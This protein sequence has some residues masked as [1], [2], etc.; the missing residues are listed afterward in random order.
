MMRKKRWKN[1]KRRSGARP[2][3]LNY[4]CFKPASDLARFPSASSHSPRSQ[5]SHPHTAS[6][7]GRGTSVGHPDNVTT[8]GRTKTILLV[9]DEKGVRGFVRA[10][11]QAKG[12]RVFEASDGEEAIH[13]AELFADKIE[14]LLTDVVLPKMDGKQ[15][16]KEVKL[17]RPETRVLF[18]SGYHVDT[19]VRRGTLQAGVN[20]LQKPFNLEALSS[21]VASVLESPRR[22]A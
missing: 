21:K 8:F 2:R 12:Y 11:L 1:N 19:L 20:F 16:A 6:H 9:D 18:M 10:A 7:S 4:S 3:F 13:I 15:V 14:L 17:L 22:E 5:T